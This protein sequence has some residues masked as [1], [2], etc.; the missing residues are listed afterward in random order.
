MPR[1]RACGRAQTPNVA[2]APFLTADAA[3]AAAG[4]VGSSYSLLWPTAPI[5]PGGEV[6]V[7]HSI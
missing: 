1:A 2:V 7:G 6:C 5:P 3:A 4:A